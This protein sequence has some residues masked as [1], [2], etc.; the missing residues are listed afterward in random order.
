MVDCMRSDKRLLPVKN[1]GQMKKMQRK[2][3]HFEDLEEIMEAEYPVI[4]ELEDKLLME[5]VSVLQ[6]AFD[7]GISRW[8]DYPSVRS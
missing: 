6:S 7:L 1:G 3:K 8:K 5:R 2:I 4:E